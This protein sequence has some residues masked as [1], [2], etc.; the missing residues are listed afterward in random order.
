MPTSEAQLQNPGAFCNERAEKLTSGRGKGMD[1][2]TADRLQTTER[3]ILGE[4]S[5]AERE[6]FEEHL[7]DCSRCMDAAWA[8]NSLQP[9]PRAFFQDKAAGHPAGRPNRW[10]DLL[11]LR[12][13][14]VLAF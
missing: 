14:P 12:P 8:P 9:K 7:F 10:L 3:Y 13:I 4:L 6:E 2:E 1:H 11:R 5:P